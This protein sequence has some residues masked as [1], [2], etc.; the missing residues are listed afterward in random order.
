M[1]YLPGDVAQWIGEEDAARRRQQQAQQLI[2]A[3]YNPVQG[4]NP[5][6]AMLASVFSTVKGNKMA[7][8]AEGKLSEI[9]AKRFDYENQQ[10]QAQAD[11]EQ[12]AADLAYERDLEKIRK[13]EEYKAQFRGP[14]KI[15]PLSPEGMRATL[16]LER[17]KIGMQPRAERAP[18]ELERK[19]AWL[20]TNG[21]GKDAIANM[22]M[23]VQSNAPSGYRAKPD[24]SL[25][26]IPGGP[27]DPAAKSSAPRQLPADMAGRVA[28]AEEYLSNADA[29]NSAIKSGALTGPIDN[30]TAAAGYGKGGEIFR[31]IQSGRDALQRTLTGAGMPA[32]EAS[33]YADRYL[34]TIGDTSETLLSKQGQLQ[35]ELGRF[36]KEARGIT[37]TPSGTLA[38][39]QQAG[40][41]ARPQTDADFAALPS[42][43]LYIDPDDGRTYRKP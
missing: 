2:Q 23:G 10:A 9:A 1:Q 15:D 39:K 34:P 3:G 27:A 25:E 21:V 36:I 19:I 41:T 33:E 16:E 24:G 14:A 17:A 26:P 29:I 31:Q 12:A 35:A 6:L 30:R 38:P 5:L 32:S 8:A 42:G 40:G 4:G 28:L 13:G 43:A 22:V 7:E 18:S 11:A 37:D 20:E